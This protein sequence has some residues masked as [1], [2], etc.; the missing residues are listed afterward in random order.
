MKKMGKGSF[1]KTIQVFSI[2]LLC[3]FLSSCSFRYINIFSLKPSS[4]GAPA[5]KPADGPPSS[6]EDNNGAGQAP[7]TT[8]DKGDADTEPSSS[9]AK[10]DGD[11]GPSSS[12]DS[13]DQDNTAPYDNIHAHKD[14][15][16]GNVKDLDGESDETI[17]NN[18]TAPADGNIGNAEG[19]NKKPVDIDG[20]GNPHG[21]DEDIKQQIEE[22]SGFDDIDAVPAAKIIRN[23]SN[24]ELKQ[25]AITFDDG[26]DDYFTPQ[27]LDILK[28]YDI[29]STFFILGSVAQNNRDILKRIDDE[30]HVVASHGWGHKNFTKLSKN[31]AIQEL[32]RTNE[33]IE[34]VTG[35]SNTLFR[36]PYGAFNK[37]VLK[38]VADEGFHNI[39]WSIDPRDWSGISPNRILNDVKKNLKPGAIILLH[40]SGSEKSIP[41]SIKALPKI[42][43]YIQGQGYDIVTIP[44]LLRDTFTE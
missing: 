35:K 7:E 22:S 1:S 21:P 15:G 36:L 40:S 27:V 43:E 39:Y 20:D 42:I 25:V 19:D 24:D 4:P 32:K 29:R 18:I 16:I 10:G 12:D 8:E 13:R 2:I 31:K 14:T 3:I 23:S 34:E 9:D 44:E 41:N 33:L 37:K 5:N 30:G 17:N 28:E 6:W 26:P 11:N 38:T